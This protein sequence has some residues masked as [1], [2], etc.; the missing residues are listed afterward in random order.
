MQSLAFVAGVLITTPRLCS[1]SKHFLDNRDS[2][3]YKP[4]QAEKSSELP[5]GNGKTLMIRTEIK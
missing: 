4:Q 2:Q 3:S 1:A 5:K